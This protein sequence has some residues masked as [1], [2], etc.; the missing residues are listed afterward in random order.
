MIKME[1]DFEN[2][3]EAYVLPEEEVYV[4]IGV[5]EDK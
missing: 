3:K 4:K 2:G 5:S 1:E